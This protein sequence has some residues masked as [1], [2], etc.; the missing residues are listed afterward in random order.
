MFLVLVVSMTK[1]VAEKFAINLVLDIWRIVQKIL[2]WD[3]E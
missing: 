3:R 1:S 2:L